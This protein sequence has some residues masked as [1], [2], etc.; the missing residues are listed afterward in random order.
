MAKNIV[1]LVLNAEQVKGFI[2][3]LANDDYWGHTWCAEYEHDDTVFEINGHLLDT[4]SNQ[5]HHVVIDNGY[6]CVN[7]GVT[8]SYIDGGEWVRVPAIDY[9]MHKLGFC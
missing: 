4:Y 2:D 7:E 3:W 6:V 8:V 9:A 5:H 1:K